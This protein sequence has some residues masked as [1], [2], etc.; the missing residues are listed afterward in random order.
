MKIS[1]VM[2]P[3]P[4]LLDEKGQPYGPIRTNVFPQPQITL[5][6]ALDKTQYEIELLD[7]RTLDNPL[8]W[9]PNLSQAYAEPINY[10]NKRLTRH[11]V[12]DF[13]QR[14]GASSKDVDVYAISANYTY[15]ANAVKETIRL[16]REHN[17]NALIIV[18]GID[19]SAASR[20]Q[21]YFNAGADYIGIGDSDLSLPQ[22]LND[23]RSGN[24]QNLRNLQEKYPNRL[25]PSKGKI[26]VVDLGLLAELNCNTLR[27]SESGGGGIIDSILYKGFPAF[28][29]MQRGCSESCSFCTAAGMSFDRLSVN[30]IKKQID[31]YIK[32]GVS[33]FMFTDDNTLLRN[34]AV[35][36]EIFDYLKQKGAS[37]EFPDGL[38]VR[39]LG[40]K[41]P[42]TGIWMPRTSL[43]DK[44]FWNNSD[45]Q[46]FAGLHR[47]LFPTED[48]LLR[49]SNLPKLKEVASQ[50]ILEELI[51]RNVPYINLAIMVGAPHETP[52]ER[53]RLEKNLERLSRIAN[54][55][56][57][58]L[59][60]S[61]FCTIPLPGTRFGEQMF[62]EGRVRYDITL[63]PELW[64][65]F[66]STLQGDYFTPEQT[67]EF[68]RQILDKH[69]MQQDLGK[70]YTVIKDK[71]KGARKL[72]SKISTKT[73]AAMA[74]ILL[75]FSAIGGSAYVKHKADSILQEEISKIP[76]FVVS[77]EW[78]G[79]HGGR[80]FINE[81][82]KKA[83]QEIEENFLIENFHDDV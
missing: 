65:V 70:V 32:N 23:V 33:L 35:L 42:V 14:I 50:Q 75:S 62:N 26:H 69:D 8:V 2:S 24:R 71:C 79:E 17:P 38:E 9:E 13:R 19:A 5:A 61:I 56:N 15:E 57:T 46:D 31:N 10:G 34:P 48:S 44:L 30:D 77:G 58:Q 54:G 72:L 78:D 49:E 7:A 67:T 39:L 64:N 3:S 37:W 1:F 81:T 68:R 51:K 63:Y 66:V 47:L 73:V 83:N 21:F 53:K 60:Y 4:A 11:L 36:E 59:N 22:F 27:F 20:H 16:L 43:M 80:W 74:A 55:T 6:T 12:G 29:E 45:Y 76:P 52:L 41:D 40:K 18:G 28:I 82:I 25:I